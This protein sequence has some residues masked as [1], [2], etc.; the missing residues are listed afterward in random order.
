MRAIQKEAW[1]D[2]P[3]LDL[4]RTGR[5]VRL[6]GRITMFLLVSS[7]VAMALLPWRQTAKGTGTVLAL[8]PQERPQPVKA[9][10]KGIVDYVKEGIRE[11]SYVEKDEIVLKLVP[12]AEGAVFQLGLEIAAEQSKKSLTV[13]KL[14]FARQQVE[15]WTSNKEFENSALDR[16]LEAASS[17]L[18]QVKNKQSFA[19]A[20]LAG[21][22]FDFESTERVGERG[23]ASTRDVIAK[24]AAFEAAKEKLNE[25]KN[26]TEQARQELEAKQK[27]VEA[28]RKQ[29]EAKVADA[30]QKKLSE[31]GAIKTI[32]AKLAQLNT[33][34]DAYK[35]LD[36]KAP[37]SG[38]I[39]EWGG[40]AGSDAVKAGEALFVIVPEVSELAVEMLIN[41][42]DMPLVHVGDRVRLQFQGWPAVQFVG[43]PSV[44]VGTFGGKVD[45][46]F[47][48]DNGKGDYRILVTADNHFE[49]EDGW[50]ID[51]Y[52][53]QGVRANGWVL[54]NRVPLGYEI[55]RQFNGFPPSLPQN[56]EKEKEKDKGSKMKVPKA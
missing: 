9:A 6:S 4:V 41:G 29:L 31:E 33:K 27:F 2:F 15:F 42:N 28:K 48:T 52:L 23:I 8:D 45:R 17:K 34:M 19:E 21:K 26:A 1:S 49:R 12:E 24:R 46:I 39:Q 55:W 11:G 37:R 56:M 43:W 51:T 25:A 22:K 35:R 50:P 36:V 47:P 16:E 32:D 3:A 13:S 18:E 38:Y 54:L 20:E 53:K 14:D 7:I 30:E 5:L 44:A 10:T 40:Y